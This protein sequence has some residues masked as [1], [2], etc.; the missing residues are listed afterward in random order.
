MHSRHDENQSQKKWQNHTYLQIF[1]PHSVFCIILYISQFVPENTCND[2]GDQL[3]NWGHEQKSL[4]VSIVFPPDTRH[5]RTNE[6]Q[7]F[8]LQLDQLC[9]IQYTKLLS[10][11]VTALPVNH[12]ALSLLLPISTGKK[13]NKSL[14]SEFYNPPIP[15]GQFSKYGVGVFQPYWGFISLQVVIYKLAARHS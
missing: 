15:V 12:I 9:S 7:C 11:D 2:S 13:V 1:L 3:G 6:G 10:I 8:L 14:K 4:I 5:N